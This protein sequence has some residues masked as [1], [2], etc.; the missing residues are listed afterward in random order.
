MRR[1][2]LL[3]PLLALALAP[4]Q[5]LAWGATGHRMTGVLAIRALTRDLPD[6]VR[7]DDAAWVVGE[8][9]R[10]PDRARGAGISHDPDLDPGHF[11]N[12]SD[13]GTVLGGPRLA[14]L[15]ATR[16]DYDTALRKTGTD[17]YHAGYLPWSIID[18]WQQLVK[19]FALWRADRAGERWAKSEADRQWFADDRQLRE[20]LTLRDLGY[21]AHFVGDGSQPMHV[22][23]HYDGWGDYPNPAGYTVEKGTHIHFEGAFVRAHVPEDAVAVLV[24][25]YRPSS[26]PIAARVSAYL[27]ATQA[28]LLPLYELEKAKAFAADDP[29]GVRFAAVRLAAAVNELRDLIAD[30]W[31]ASADAKL[32]YPPVDLK[33]IESGKADAKAVLAGED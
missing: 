23:V 7:S 1:P 32:G 26:E 25:P 8:I 2:I 19:D 22:S 5:V 15:P 21:W 28:E 29:R 9:A 20:H 17:E 27:A 30:A 33:D 24:S 12:V 14:S 16:E 18:G 10:E 13:D 3:V 4:G 31:A 11:V 6:F